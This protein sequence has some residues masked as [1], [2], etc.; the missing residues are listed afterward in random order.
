VDDPAAVIEQAMVAIR[1]S[2]GRRTLHRR[3]AGGEASLAEA[4]TFRVLDAIEA[5]GDAGRVMTVTGVADAEVHG[6]RRQAV[7]AALAG[8]SA[9][10]RDALAR[11]LRA[12]VSSWERTTRGP[13]T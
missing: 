3:R 1:R 13:A 5:A 4:A 6:T 2:Q 9:D 11:L 7:E 12:F 10:D 8:W